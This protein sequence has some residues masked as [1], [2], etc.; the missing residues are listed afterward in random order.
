MK[1]NTMIKFA[2]LFEIDNNQI[3]ITKDYDY[4]EDVYLLKQRT[5]FDEVDP[6]MSMSFDSEEKRDNAFNDYNQDNAQKFLNL[7]SSVI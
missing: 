6:S 5:S 3:L 1:N 2:K 7:V 4:D